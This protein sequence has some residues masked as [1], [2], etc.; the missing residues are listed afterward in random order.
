MIYES[1]MDRGDRAAENRHENSITITH[2]QGRALGHSG[3]T[4]RFFVGLSGGGVERSLAYSHSHAPTR[5]WWL[6]S[7]S[8]THTHKPCSSSIHMHTYAQ[9]HSQ[10]TSFMLSFSLSIQRLFMFTSSLVHCSQVLFVYK[11]FLKT[12]DM[13][14]Y[15]YFMTER[16]LIKWI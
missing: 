13:F 6:S 5:A 14:S 16:L 1:K 15:Q 8:L 3:T 7:F 4:R 2:M 12:M 10:R 11:P 9:S